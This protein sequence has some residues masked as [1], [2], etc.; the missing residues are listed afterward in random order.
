MLNLKIEPLK[1]EFIDIAWKRLNNLTKPQGSLGRLEEIA[2]RVV[3]IYEDAMPEIKKKAV[4]VFASDHGVTEENVS[5]YPKEVTA[6]MVFNFLRGG[7]GINVLARHA[8]A[9]VLVVDVGVDYDFSEINGLIKKK[10]VKGSGNIAKGY[11]L[12][13]D[14]AIKSVDIGI[15]LVRECY[16][17]G[18]NLFATGEMGIGNTTV[19][20]AVV[21]VLTNSDVEEVTGRG[22]GIDETTFKRKVEVIKRAIEI[23]KPDASDPIDV[24]AKVGG[25]EIGAIAGVVLGCASLR[26][27]VIVDGFIS[28]AG[29][30]IAYCINPLVKDY[31]FASHNSVEKGHKK[32]LDFMGLKPLL[33]LNLRLGE[34]TG[35]TLAMTVIEA[36]LKIY[37]EM[38][39]FEEA[40]VSKNDK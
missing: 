40:G 10:V 4:L 21:S 18:Y 35:A 17:R 12:S 23:N 29:A 27:P 39:T 2:S 7:A 1:K 34:G 24:L 19:S 38:S 13:R 30:L 5:A 22:T 11:A 16:S 14:D 32:A 9:D 25:P 37:R 3:A 20:S 6:Q 33:D 15:E 8:G 36:S 28:T 31:I 26:V